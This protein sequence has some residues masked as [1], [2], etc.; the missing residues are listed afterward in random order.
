MELTQLRYFLEVAST[1]H[2]TASAEKLHI[3]QPA[4]S[5]AIHRLEASLGVPLF[6]RRGRNIVLTEYGKYLRSHAEPIVEALDMLPDKLQTMA[7][8]QDE[9]IHVNVLAASLLVTNAIIEYKRSHSAL[10][11]QLLQN[12]QSDVYDVEISTKMFC[13]AD[14]LQ[15]PMQ[16]V[17]TEKIFLA[18]PAQ[19]GRYQYSDSITL[20]E[21]ENEGFISL[22]GYRQLG[23]IFQLLCQRVGFQPR[24]VFESDSPAAVQNMIGANLGIGFWPEFS[25][26]HPDPEKVRLLELRDPPCSRELIMTCNRNKTDNSVVEDFFRF[27]TDYCQR[28]KSAAARVG[29]VT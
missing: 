4:L 25:W 22:M 17:C 9:T 21:V 12:S 10:N 8:L 24:I 13:P 1:Q 29:G 27:L 11:F 16:F 23:H 7:H 26:G 20:R 28:Q 14:A 19:A 6:S 3:A 15:S 18:V 5:Q 2:M